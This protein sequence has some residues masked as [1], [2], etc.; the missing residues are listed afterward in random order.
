MYI[1]DVYIYLKFGLKTVDLGL[2]SDFFHAVGYTAYADR[3]MKHLC[4][5]RTLTPLSA[6]VFKIHCS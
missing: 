3:S 4:S 5:F 1:A 2:A 6:A